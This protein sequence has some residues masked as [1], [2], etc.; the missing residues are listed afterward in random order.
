MKNYENEKTSKLERRIEKAIE[1]ECMKRGLMGNEGVSVTLQLTDEE[2]NEFL[3][4]DLGE[5]Y[6]WW[7]FET[8]G[9]LT[10]SVANLDKVFLASIGEVELI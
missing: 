7:E 4:T 2:K 9:K 3:K 5:K 10:V 6:D 1:K 8:D